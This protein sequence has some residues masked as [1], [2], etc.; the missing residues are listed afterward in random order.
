MISDT[1]LAAAA[2]LTD[3]LTSPTH[4]KVYVGEMRERIVRLRDEMDSIRRELDKPPSA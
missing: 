1:L 4:A 2:E 3:Y